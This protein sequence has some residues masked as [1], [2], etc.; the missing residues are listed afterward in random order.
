[1]KR[2]C[3]VNRLGMAD[4]GAYSASLSLPKAG[5]KPNFRGL[6]ERK[7]S[8]HSLVKVKQRVGNCKYLARSYNSIHGVCKYI[9]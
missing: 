5:D 4:E 1:M 2:I 3:W 9:H 6:W 8:E 7:K